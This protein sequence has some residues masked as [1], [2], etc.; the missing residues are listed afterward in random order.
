M[1]N[2]P[3]WPADWYQCSRARLRLVLARRGRLSQWRVVTKSSDDP[4]SRGEVCPRPIGEWK[5]GC[6]FA[7]HGQIAICT[8]VPAA[9]VVRPE[10]A[11]VADELMLRRRWKKPAPALLLRPVVSRV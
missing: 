1:G 10:V 5:L 4:P 11:H 3:I 9:T 7:L 6:Q 2:L 8:D